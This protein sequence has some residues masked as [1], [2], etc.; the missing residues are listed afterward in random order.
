MK[1]KLLSILVLFLFCISF[2]TS[3]AKK[4]K[5]LFKIDEK[6]IT[7]IDILNETRYLMSINKELKN[8]EKNKIYE[9]AKLLYE[10]K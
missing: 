6:I 7:S 8:I 2:S 4:N 1:K 5:I 10:I 3:H 9:L